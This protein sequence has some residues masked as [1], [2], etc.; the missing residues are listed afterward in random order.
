M[1]DAFLYQ[2]GDATVDYTAVADIVGGQIVQI[3]DGR[4]AVVPTDIDQSEAPLGSAS[5]EGIYTVTKAANLVWV[6]G[7]EI[8]WDHSANAA[9]LHPASDK[10]FYLGTA[11][12]DVAAA[13]TTGKVSLNTKPV[14]KI[15]ISRGGISDATVTAIVLTAGTV[16]AGRIG[17]SDRFTFSATAEAQKADILSKQGFAVGSNW[18]VEGGFTVVDDGDAAAIDFNIGLANAT[19]ASDADAITESCFLHLDG[20]ALDL[21]AE[22]DDGTTEVAATDTTVNIALGTPVHFVMDG[23][24]EADIQIYVNGVLQLG[25]TVFKLD[26]ATGP[27]KLLAHL[28]KSSDD[29]TAEYYIDYLRVRIANE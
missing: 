14:Y 4:A 26:A 10:D 6:D 27:M 3:P 15:D 5:T 9:V 20:N 8:Y 23:R 28:E 16:G 24:N 2:E 12:G 25:S 7:C 22:S 29:T 19:H 11:V 13:T 21:F 18:I 17:G 1:S